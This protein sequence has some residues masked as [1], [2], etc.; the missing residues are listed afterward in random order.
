MAAGDEELVDFGAVK[1]KLIGFTHRSIHAA[2][3][4]RNKQFL[5]SQIFS[6][7]EIL[8]CKTIDDSGFINSDNGDNFTKTMK[9]VHWYGP[10]CTWEDTDVIFIET[11]VTLASHYASSAPLLLE[12][13]TTAACNLNPPDRNHMLLRRILLGFAEI[14]K[15]SS[16]LNEEL[17]FGRSDKV[18]VQELLAG[19]T[20]IPSLA[21]GKVFIIL[22]LTR[23]AVEL[24]LRSA[25][26]FFFRKTLLSIMSKTWLKQPL[27]R[28]SLPL[29][30]RTAQNYFATKA[31]DTLS[32]VANNVTD[33][34]Y[35]DCGGKLRSTGSTL[36]QLTDLL[37]PAILNQ[38][39]LDMGPQQFEDDGSPIGNLASIASK[40][41]S[42]ATFMLELSSWKETCLSDPQLTSAVLARVASWFSPI[43]P[44]RLSQL[45]D[46]SEGKRFIG[47][48]FN[49]VVVDV[50]KWAMDA[51]SV[52][53][54]GCSISDVPLV[55]PTW[56]GVNLSRV[57]QKNKLSEKI[58]RLRKKYDSFV[59]K[60]TGLKTFILCCSN[61][62]PS[63]M[64]L[65]LDYLVTKIEKCLGIEVGNTSDS[66]S[67]SQSSSTGSDFFRF[68]PILEFVIQLLCYLSP[69]IMELHAIVRS[70]RRLTCIAQAI[71]QRILCLD[72][73]LS[74]YSSKTMSPNSTVKIY[75]KYP[76]DTAILRSDGAECNQAALKCS[77]Y[78]F[79]TLC[80]GIGYTVTQRF[81]CDDSVSFLLHCTDWD[82]S[83]ALSSLFLSHHSGNS[84]NDSFAR[85]M[86]LSNKEEDAS[87]TWKCSYILVAHPAIEIV[88]DV[89]FMPYIGT[90][91]CDKVSMRTLCTH[92]SRLQ[93]DPKDDFLPLNLSNIFDSLPFSSATLGYLFV[94]T[95]SSESRREKDSTAHL[96]PNL[97]YLSNSDFCR[98]SRQ[99]AS[100]LEISLI[101]EERTTSRIEGR[102][103]AD[104]MDLSTF[105][106]DVLVQILS[107][108]SFKRVCRMACVSSGVSEASKETSL[109]EILYK[110][111]FRNFVF[112][113]YVLKESA[114]SMMTVPDCKECVGL[115]PSASRRGTKKQ[116]PCHFDCRRH[117][118]MDL[119]QVNT[120]TT[121][122]PDICKSRICYLVQLQHTFL[123]RFL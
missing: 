64:E 51:T 30:Q 46:S 45:S 86:R 43:S 22:S 92:C 56:T 99:L 50:V 27:C 93:I 75:G 18:L 9:D 16:R 61:G 32:E 63:N 57:F 94:P 116:K 87:D 82:V 80:S 65:L 52:I 4:R 47:S 111:K 39:V 8:L 110:R 29:N 90:E 15:F 85:N 23:V 6:L 60:F 33:T 7:V 67:Y 36:A 113:N 98:L 70:T 1:A 2:A 68:F 122:R 109:W 44:T 48:I 62:S 100:R 78:A 31:V 108:L 66:V 20:C 101:A 71:K 118:W 79:V 14:I 114:Q 88:M 19:L 77:V 95:E 25:F 96:L 26:G 117:S 13:L 121:T 76:F 49:T 11:F 119:F 115:K 28:L 12:I 41:A 103:S 42:D 35:G 69:R 107:F 72:L 74:E 3:M 40:S 38:K 105:S 53:F 58:H 24:R 106:K 120:T 84:L 54:K 91:D 112:E 34:M 102:V 123:I 37:E 55:I 81:S 89:F 73:P 5:K 104:G 10:N 83:S 59:T 21:S 17:L 97:R